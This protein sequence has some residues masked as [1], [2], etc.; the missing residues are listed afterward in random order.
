MVIARP[1][2]RN[3]WNEYFDVVG[4]VHHEPLGCGWNTFQNCVSVLWRLWDQTELRCLK[5]VVKTG[6]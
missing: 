1:Q 6:G 3:G 5:S 2:S 4:W